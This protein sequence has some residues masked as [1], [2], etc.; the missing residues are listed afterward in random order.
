M[1]LHFSKRYN[2][3]NN[4]YIESVYNVAETQTF[5][6]DEDTRA[7]TGSNAAMNLTLGLILFNSPNIANLLKD[8]CVNCASV[9]GLN[10]SDDCHTRIV[11]IDLDDESCYLT[12]YDTLSQELKF[13][14]YIANTDFVTNIKVNILNTVGR[15]SAQL[16]AIQNSYFI[17]KTNTS[18][19]DLKNYFVLQ[20]YNIV[21]TG[22]NIYSHVNGIVL[23][24]HE[25]AKN[26][27][28][29][30]ILDKFVLTSKKLQDIYDLCNNKPKNIVDSNYLLSTFSESSF[31]YNNSA[32]KMAHFACSTPISDLHTDQD[33]VAALALTPIQDTPVNRIKPAWLTKAIEEH[34][35]TKG[36]PTLTYDGQYYVTELATSKAYTYSY[37][38]KK[39]PASECRAFIISDTNNNIIDCISIDK[40]TF[41]IYKKIM[42]LNKIVFEDLYVYDISIKLN[43]VTFNRD[44][45]IFFLLNQTYN[46]PK[47]DSFAKETIIDNLIKYDCTWFQERTS[48]NNNYT[49]EDIFA[50]ELE[51]A[52][53]SNFYNSSSQKYGLFT[54]LVNLAWNAD[55]FDS[56][57]Y[58]KNVDKLEL[59]RT[60]KIFM[61]E[62]GEIKLSHDLMFDHAED[63]IQRGKVHQSSEFNP[64]IIGEFTL[65]H[66][67][68]TKRALNFST[69]TL[70]TPNGTYKGN[71]LTG[72]MTL[73]NLQTGRIINTY[74]HPFTSDTLVATRATISNIN[75][76]YSRLLGRS[77][78]SGN[79]NLYMKSYIGSDLIACDYLFNSVELY[80]RRLLLSSQ[81]KNVDPDD[82]L[83]KNFSGFINYPI[84]TS[85][86]AAYTSGRL[87]RAQRDKILYS[88]LDEAMFT[89][90]KTSAICHNNNIDIGSVTMHEVLKTRPV[91]QGLQLG[92]IP[93]NMDEY[94]YYY[95][96]DKTY[97]KDIKTIEANIQ[98]IG[99]TKE[100]SLPTFNT[101]YASIG[102]IFEKEQ[103]WLKVRT[104]WLVSHPNSAFIKPGAEKIFWFD[105]LHTL[106]LKDMPEKA[107]DIDSL[108]KIWTGMLSRMSAMTEEEELI[109]SIYDSFEELEI[110]KHQ[111]VTAVNDEDEQEETPV[112]QPEQIEQPIVETV[113]TPTT[114]NNTASSSDD[115]TSILDDTDAL[116]ADL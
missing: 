82:Y 67:K 10:L 22:N 27:D 24:L 57:N 79:A 39:T 95:N 49:W 50:I 12:L 68:P 18:L 90:I 28:K 8:K 25:L 54:K 111:E 11:F 100:Q 23:S 16:S 36:E 73:T 46:Y 19:N 77:Y 83:Y 20:N 114:N 2:I 109:Q 17:A 4:T 58:K 81:K 96:L 32:Y 6:H 51:F 99:N 5:K 101:A 33:L 21:K 89:Y 13:A 44:Q 31:T 55:F 38:W 84:L 60:Y 35:V 91:F 41:N 42:E 87:E 26:S 105:V 72:A 64:M 94:E 75:T 104:S 3:K 61:K 9:M 40:I 98:P 63:I 65:K 97:S 85:E 93:T 56:L 37:S 110:I 112:K 66:R 70:E 78:Y 59:Q 80:N 115:S 76:V 71:V 52:R 30:M 47:K 86:I 45:L 43:D 1:I 62:T 108:Y 88:D 29:Y 69:I 107:N 48:Q 53:Y 113:E 15:K 14:T 116:F 92:F 7:K 34:K 102:N 74:C 103:A 106:V